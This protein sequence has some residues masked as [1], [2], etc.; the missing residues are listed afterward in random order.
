MGRVYRTILCTW[1]LALCWL[2]PSAQGQTP[3]D[4]PGISIVRQE[5]RIVVRVGDELFTRYDFTSWAKPIFYPVFAPGQIPMTR[6]HPMQS[7]PG[8]AS[9]HPHHKSIWFAHGD[10]N[11][12]DFWSEKGRIA[13]QRF[14]EPS[15]G[16]HFAVLDH[17]LDP[18]TGHP[19]IACRGEFAFGSEDDQRWIDCLYTFQAEFGAVTFGDTKEGMFAIRTHPALRLE[20]DPARG[21][22]HV[23]GQ[24]INSEG[25]RG[26]AIWGKPAR[27]VHYQGVIDG[28]SAGIAIMDHPDNLRHPTTWHARAYGLVAA[29]PFGLHHFQQQPRGSGDY[30]LESGQQ[31]VF[32]YRMIFHS[33]TWS[34]QRVEHAFDQFQRQDGN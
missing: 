3:S 11:G 20:P 8:Q 31:L 14:V 30:R 27:W 10:V 9:D 2:I 23:T 13:H 19:V 22:R 7:I 25:V 17:W 1:G 4:P 6:D 5:T 28:H 26:K 12:I 16:R 32:R 24:A 15:E 21:V 34:P 29:N 18:A 33:G